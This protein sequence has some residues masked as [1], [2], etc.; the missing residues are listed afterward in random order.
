MTQDT[1]ELL[2]AWLGPERDAAAQKYET[3]RAG[4]IRVF[5]ARGCLEAEDLAD[6]TFNRVAGKVAS[7]QDT[8]EGNP[9]RYFY[10]VADKLR[11]EY[12]RRQ[13]PRES[14]EDHPELRAATV[15]HAEETV[16]HKCLGHCLRE[17]PED[18]RQF[19]LTYY[20]ENK[21][22]KIELHQDMAEDLALTKQGLRT[23]A[24]R[25]KGALHKCIEK[26]LENGKGV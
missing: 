2:L 25:L 4:L 18:Q 5:I 1:F 7:L 8:Y 20:S 3:I 6:E 16:E 10:G 23:R 15:E 9:I 17:L 21:R 14:I 11:L 12:Q 13:R 22:A 26:C 19:I 24:F